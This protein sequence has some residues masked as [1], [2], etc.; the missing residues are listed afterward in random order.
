M[1]R[2]RAGEQVVVL[3]DGIVCCPLVD[4]PK[5]KALKAGVEHLC[6]LTFAVPQKV[7]SFWDGCRQVSAVTFRQHGT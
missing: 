3:V 5:D 1:V 6:T 7:C 2:L 4:P